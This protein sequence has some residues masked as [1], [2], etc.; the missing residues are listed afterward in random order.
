M[1]KQGR[2]GKTSL[3]TELCDTVGHN[4][5]VLECHCQSRYMI[6]RNEGLFTACLQD[7]RLCGYGGYGDGIF[8]PLSPKAQTVRS[9]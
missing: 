2:E 9:K 1:R 3:D 6:K 5:S 7:A 8:S 4:R